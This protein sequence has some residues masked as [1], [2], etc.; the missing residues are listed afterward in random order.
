MNTV[1]NHV[2]DE[3]NMRIGA[4][5]ERF[6]VVRSA[7]TVVKLPATVE[8]TLGAVDAADSEV[9]SAALFVFL[10]STLSDIS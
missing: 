4:V 2:G 7:V 5:C 1:L 6:E 3:I 8:L 9:L 10:I